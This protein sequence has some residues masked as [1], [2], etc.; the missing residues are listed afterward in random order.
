MDEIKV[1]Q[2]NKRAVYSIQ[3][4]VSGGSL[5]RDLTA[6]AVMVTAE[7]DLGNLPAYPAGTLAYTAGFGSMW[8]LSSAGEWV[9]V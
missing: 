3:D 7:S 1:A 4:V 2:A 5:I 8:Q 6:P 9:E